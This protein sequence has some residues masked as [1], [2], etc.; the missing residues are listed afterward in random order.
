MASLSD[1][2]MQ[3]RSSNP[4]NREGAPERNALKI[5]LYL[6]GPCALFSFTL[7]LWTLLAVVITVLLQ[8]LRCCSF[9]PS[10]DEQ[11]SGFLAPPLKLQ[12]LLIYSPATSNRYKP[13]MLV[14]VHT[15]SVFVALGVALAS[16]VAAFFWFF[17]A[18]LGDPAGQDGHNDGRATVLGVRNWWERWLLRASS[19]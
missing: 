4:D 8:P 18:I 17:S 5:L 2:E 11:L 13:S 3:I 19:V 12:L 6:S 1:A 16:W 14:L 9:R 7:L 15:F 10:F